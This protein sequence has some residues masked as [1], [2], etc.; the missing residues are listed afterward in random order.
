M[1]FNTFNSVEYALCFHKVVGGCLEY[2]ESKGL[3]NKMDTLTQLRMG[4]LVYY[5]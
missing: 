4:C 3:S 2:A 1:L 5:L